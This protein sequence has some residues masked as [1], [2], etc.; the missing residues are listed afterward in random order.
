MRLKNM[1][2]PNTAK[3]LDRR[4]MESRPVVGQAAS[5]KGM[6]LIPLQAIC[7]EPTKPVAYQ[8]RPYGLPL[9][10]ATR[11]RWQPFNKVRRCLIWDQVA[12]LMCSFPPDGS[13]L[14]ARSMVSI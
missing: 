9:V 12:A 5:L 13:D 7:M 14:L 1:F 4:R 2:E 8:R 10:V 3:P 11:Q 6:R